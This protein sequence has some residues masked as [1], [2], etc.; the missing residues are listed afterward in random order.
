MSLR[1]PKFHMKTESG[2]DA[3][4]GAIR[5]RKAAQCAGQRIHQKLVQ[6]QIVRPAVRNIAVFDSLVLERH[7][8]ERLS[9]LSTP[10]AV[11]AEHKSER[12]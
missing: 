2:G 3:F 6:A 12:G 8:V 9:L 7:A 11:R 1:L 10:D 5:Y 4:G